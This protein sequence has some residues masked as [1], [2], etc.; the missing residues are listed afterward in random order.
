[1]KVWGSL[2]GSERCAALAVVGVLAIA[3]FFRFFML[4]EIGIRGDDTLYYLSLA[5]GWAEPARE[6]YRLVILG[7]YEF[8]LWWVDSDW[9]VKALNAGLDVANV[10]LLYRISPANGARPLVPTPTWLQNAR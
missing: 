3:A 7:I 8:V 10:L 9:S 1:M 5:R 2:S 4:S 6:D